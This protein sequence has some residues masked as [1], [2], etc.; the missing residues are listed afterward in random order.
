MDILTFKK[1][2]QGYTVE[3]LETKLEK[4]NHEYNIDCSMDGSGELSVL[5]WESYKPYIYE[6]EI[7]LKKRG[8]NLNQSEVED[9]D[10]D[11]ELPF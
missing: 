7:E 8:I 3:Q 5:I 1:E 11:D 6:V 10:W 4:L 9:F 2:I